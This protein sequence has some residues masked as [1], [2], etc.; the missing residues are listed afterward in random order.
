MRPTISEQVILRRIKAADPE[1]YDR[2]R[3]AA[4]QLACILAA[5][6]TLAPEKKIY[7]S[8]LLFFDG[9]KVGFG[10]INSFLGV[11]ALWRISGRLE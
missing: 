4:E 11:L 3:E 6:P 1:N 2:D 5:W 10:L 7:I 9:I 8:T